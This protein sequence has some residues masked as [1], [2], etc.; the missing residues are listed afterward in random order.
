MNSEIGVVTGI[1]NDGL[2]ILEKYVGLP[3][4]QEL[5]AFVNKRAADAMPTVMVFGVYNAGKSTFLNALIGDERAPM[6]DRPE[7]SRVTPYEW[8]G[9][10]ILDTPGIDAPI[11]HEDVTRKQLSESDIVLFVLSTSGSFDEKSIYDE[12]LGVVRDGKPIM[13]IVNNKDG[14]AEADSDYLA[15]RDKIIRNIDAAGAAQDLQNRSSQVPVRLVNAKLALKGKITGNDRLVA[16][17]GIGTLAREIEALLKQSGTHEVAVTLGG[18]VVKLIDAGLA[19]SISL[20]S[21]DGTQYLTERHSA[22]R[23]E[24]ERVT[25]SVTSAVHRA[26]ATFRTA[27]H[28]AIENNDSIAMQAAAENAVAATTLAL[29]REIAAAGT[30]LA[31]IGEALD[32]AEP[33][34]IAVSAPGFTSDAGFDD[35]PSSPSLA[36]PVLNTIGDIASRTDKQAVEKA[37]REA[38]HYALKTTKDVAPSLLKGFG[39]K[40]M[41]KT[42]DTVGRFAGKAAPFIGP[43]IEAAK[44]I[45]EY[46]KVS[47]VQEAMA[48][49]MKRRAQALAEH[50]E[51]GAANLEA[52]LLDAT[53]AVLQPL[54]IPVEESLSKKVKE[55][56]RE[57]QAYVSDR[58]TLELM[59]L[60]IE[61]ALGLSTG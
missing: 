40:G 45:F 51:Q 7:T 55:L 21:S 5:A 1:L 25:A 39:K 12:I 19:K 44:G 10:R 15:I 6:A 42:A 20:E 18:R 49:R 8:N 41:E 24:K 9:F 29:E 2:P 52:E 22:V 14:Y 35:D 53:R 13:V 57:A 17:S 37:T 54:F 4:T 32:S 26:T 50:A 27:F 36:E 46:Y 34:R 23:G 33:V 3:A 31:S 61:T 58:Q 56:N 43:A 48:Q 28:A 47:Q 11:E 30:I 60:R 16:A 38:M 59:K